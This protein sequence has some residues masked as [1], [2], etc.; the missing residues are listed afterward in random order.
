MKTARQAA[1]EI[2]TLINSRAQSPRID[3]LEAAIAGAMTRQHACARATAEGDPSLCAL[4]QKLQEVNQLYEAAKDTDDWLPARDRADAADNDLAELSRRIFATRPI[5]LHNL[6][7]RAVLA[8]YWHQ[9]GDDAEKWVT[10]DDCDAWEDQV[11][12]H[13]I[14]GVLQIDTPPAQPSPELLEAGGQEHGR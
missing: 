14:E 5:T 8:K 7:L 2:A 9:Y 3:E 6:K 11:V 13:L 4:R 1:E 10:P 12:A